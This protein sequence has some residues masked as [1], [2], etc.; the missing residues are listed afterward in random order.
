MSFSKKFVQ[1]LLFSKNIDDGIYRSVEQIENFMTTL[2]YPRQQNGTT[3]Q[4]LSGDHDEIIEIATKLVEEEDIYVLIRKA[5]IPR[6][7]SLF[8]IDHEHTFKEVALSRLQ[9][10][11]KQS[12]KTFTDTLTDAFVSAGKNLLVMFAAATTIGI[13]AKAAT[14]IVTSSIMKILHLLYSMIFSSSSAQRIEQSLRIVQQSAE[15]DVSIPFL[16]AMIIDHLIGPSKKVCDMIWGSRHIDTVM[17]RLGYLGD[18]KVDRG[19]ERLVEW[20]IKIIKHTQGWFYREVL[21]ISVPTD[22]E[23]SSHV[24]IKWNEE[25]EDVLK[26]YYD[27]SFVWTDMTWSLIY[28]LYSRGLSFTRSGLYDKWKSDVYRVV[29]KL[30]NILE[31]FRQRNRS[32]QSIRNPPVVLYLFGGTGVGKTSI[33]Y[34][35]SA[36]ILKTVFEREK[37]KVDLLNN[38]KRFVY[39]RAPE[40]DFWDGFENQF[41][42]VFDDF[43]Q[44]VDSSANPSLELFE[45]IRAGNCFPY[46]LHMASLDQ[47]ANT[48]FTSKIIMVSS[49]QKKPQTASLNFPTALERRFDICV[50]VTRKDEYTNVK[51]DKFNP[52]IYNFYLYDMST[53]KMIRQV[54]FE[55]IIKLSVDKYFDRASFVD[56]MDEYIRN[57][58]QEKVEHVNEIP[59]E[60]A[61]RVDSNDID[62]DMLDQYAWD[63]SIPNELS[64]PEFRDE[65][66]N[67][68]DQSYLRSL[69]TTQGWISGFF[70]KKTPYDTLTDR[71][72]E[73]IGVVVNPF[74]ALKQATSRLRL[75][76]TDLELSW[77]RFR[78]EH[79]YVVKSLM[80]VSLLVGALVFLKMF[81][82]VTQ[83]TTGKSVTE[84]VNSKLVSIKELWRDRTPRSVKNEAYVA[85]VI[86]PIK[87]EAYNPRIIQSSPK[88]EAYNPSVVKP[89]KV[90]SYNQPMLRPIKAEAIEA[91]E[92]DPATG[93]PVSQGVKD[94][95][96]TEILLAIVRRNLYKM[97]ESTNNTPIGHC[98]FLKGKI[99]LMPKHFMYSLN[100]SLR[101][102]PQATINFKSVLLQRAFEIRIK[103]LLLGVKPFESPEELGTPTSRDLM[104]VSVETAIIHPDVTSYFASRDS[105]S[106]VNTTEI[107]LPIMINNN[108]KYANDNGVVLLRFRT[109][110]TVLQTITELPVGDD[111]AEVKRYI[112]DAWRYEADTQPSECGAPLIVRNSRIAPGK[113]CGIHIAGIEGTGEGFATPLYFDDVERILAMFPDKYLM[114]QRIQREFLAFPKEQGQIPEEA[115]FIRHGALVHPIYQAAISTIEP[116]LCYGKIK[117]VETRVCQLR[118]NKDFDPRAYRLQRLGNI[119]Q[120]IPRDIVENAGQA[121][122]DECSSVIASSKSDTSNLKAV[123]SFEEA[124]LGIDGEP[125]VNSIKRGTSPGFPYIQ[126]KETKQRKLF[127]GSGDE[128]DLTTEQCQQLKIRVNEIIAAANRNEVLDHYFVDTLKDERKPIHKAHKTRLFAA[129]PLDYLVVCKM[130]FNGVVALLQKSRNWSHVSVGTNPYSADWGEIART[131]LRKS[132]RMVAGDFEGFDASQHQLLLEA[133]GE[134]FIQLSKRHLGATDADERVMRVLLVSLFNSFHISGREVY[135]WTHSLPSGHYLTA[136]INSVFVNIVFA[137]IWQI[138]FNDCSYL[139]ARSFWNE[140]GIVAYG[141]DHIVSIPANRTEIFNQLSIP[142]YFKQIGLSYT[143]EDKDAEATRPYRNLYEVTYLKRAFALDEHGMWLA[144][145]SLQT[146]LETP[147]WMHRNPDPRNQT[148]ENLEWAVKELSLHSR[149]VWNQWFPKLQE[150]MVALRHYTRLINQDDA[151]QVCLAQNIEM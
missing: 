40:Q 9:T 5:S 138:A 51:L 67:K 26:S 96:A 143:M 95:N 43:N 73:A 86:Q 118:K 84:N 124:I 59:K 18:P 102:D 117:K 37:I 142:Q 64:L 36:H 19:I 127:F 125:Y 103:D 32:G 44:Q 74:D 92:F 93:F 53:Q 146:V 13:L 107:M 114:H 89:I 145:L 31:Q 52:D 65:W 60:Q 49:N 76:Y 111:E 129:G 130:Y 108:G 15:K 147:M 88:I 110:E 78:E 72:K 101:I 150:Q 23:S 21:G 120:A 139:A 109:G 22:I 7:Q 58:L 71:F 123:Y 132:K 99:A 79:P 85:K 141:D 4:S 34:P 134:V 62:D 135:Q 137:C 27:G 90:E 47:K 87:V 128:Y 80:V 81:K 54:T 126:Q 10:L 77:R 149:E 148:I 11:L 91:V 140:C 30:G 56:S 105:L 69:F 121:F 113:I 55:D 14:S 112:R 94:L 8:S 82:M 119:P 115:E 6:Q 50:E 131:L 66:V 100:Q 42:T 46:P 57:V 25:V 17:R 29:N 106:R 38:W 48:S 116:S 41:V 12:Q 144:P 1:Y 151:R 122:L 35:L 75:S 98:L 83:I 70:K 3:F 28:N 104:A 63:D 33:T 16:P 133:A 97:F 45:I 136:P 2:Q 20:F 39:M 24:I 61:G 68:H